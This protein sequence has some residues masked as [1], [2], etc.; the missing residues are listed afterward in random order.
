VLSLS[1]HRDPTSA[2]RT[3]MISAG[4]DQVG[5]APADPTSGAV[6]FSFAPAAV[7]RQ[8]ELISMACVEPVETFG[9]VVPPVQTSLC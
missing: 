9:G 6:G 7:D 1:K 8:A 5:P 4:L 3:T 2:P